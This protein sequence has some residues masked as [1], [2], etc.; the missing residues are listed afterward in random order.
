MFI[1]QVQPGGASAARPE[2]ARLRRALSPCHQPDADG[3]FV[4]DSAWL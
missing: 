4:G 3:L 2:P 1:G